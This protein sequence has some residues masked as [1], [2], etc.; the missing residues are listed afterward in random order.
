MESERE[1]HHAMGILE[2]KDHKA[3]HHRQSVHA[4]DGVG[5]TAGAWE[6][7]FQT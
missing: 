6:G 7:G 2:N 1:R 3:T 5:D 4:E